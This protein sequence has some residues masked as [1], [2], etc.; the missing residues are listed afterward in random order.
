MILFK[1]QIRAH[2]MKN[3]IQTKVLHWNNGN[4]IIVIGN[5]SIS[6]KLIKDECKYLFL[7]LKNKLIINYKIL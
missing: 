7:Y 2:W 6:K 3:I 4:K 1:S 5:K